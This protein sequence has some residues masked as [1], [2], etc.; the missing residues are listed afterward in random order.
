MKKLALSLL[1]VLTLSLAA[2]VTARADDQTAAPAVA[3][4][5]TATAPVPVAVDATTGIPTGS[6]MLPAHTVTAAAPA[7]TAAMPAMPALPTVKTVW[8]ILAWVIGG[9][10][11]WLGWLG[12]EL[13]ACLP[14]K[15]NG[16]IQGGMLLLK[17]ISF[18]PDSK[19]LTVQVADMQ[20]ALAEMKA[21]VEGSS[22]TAADT[23]AA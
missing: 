19:A 22:S 18:N 10:F 15:F 21:Q 16:F 4:V 8:T 17:S 7:V 12:S 9:L 14:G 13:M 20:T 11:P 5:A 3:T 2:C 23:K 1:L 6:A